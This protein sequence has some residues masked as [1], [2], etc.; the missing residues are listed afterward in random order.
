[1]SN[2]IQMNSEVCSLCGEAA[3][4]YADLDMTIA[5]RDEPEERYRAMVHV[6]GLCSEWLKVTRDTQRPPPSP[7][8]YCPEQLELLGMAKLHADAFARTR[9]EL[10]SAHGEQAPIRI[11]SALCNCGEPA[12]MLT[13][14]G[15]VCSRCLSKVIR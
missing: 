12:A 1:M 15:Y 10:V 9:R 6:C 7:P 14:G 2:V 4:I 11:P 3:T 8:D 13:S 5:Y